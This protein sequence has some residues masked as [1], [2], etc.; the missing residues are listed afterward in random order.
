[1]TTTNQQ[2]QRQL[3]GGGGHTGRAGQGLPLRGQ[4]DTRAGSAEVKAELEH[5]A[6]QLLDTFKITDG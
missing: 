5:V 2:I 6:Y 3:V 4:V 1:M